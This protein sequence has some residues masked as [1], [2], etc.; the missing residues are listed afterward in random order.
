MERLLNA[1]EEARLNHQELYDIA[2][3]EAS[4]AVKAQQAL[5]RIVEHMEAEKVPQT[6]QL[7]EL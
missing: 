6:L 4:E 7:A 3:E 1:A 2:T 5:E